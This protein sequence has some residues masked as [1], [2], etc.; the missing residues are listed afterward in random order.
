ML[1]IKLRNYAEIVRFVKIEL[2]FEIEIKIP[3]L[4]MNLSK[5]K[6]DRNKLESVMFIKVWECVVLKPIKE[7][8][9]KFIAFSFA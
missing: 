3:C 6:F 1:L 8:L 7:Q 2:E 5:E 4:W 9:N